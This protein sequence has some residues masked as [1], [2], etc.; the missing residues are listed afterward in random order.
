MPPVGSD[1]FILRVKLRLTLFRAFNGTIQLPDAAQKVVV[2]F[3]VPDAQLRGVVEA[4]KKEV[5]LGLAKDGQQIK[6]LPSFVTNLPPADLVSSSL[7][8]DLGGTNFRVCSVSMDRGKVKLE[9]EKFTIPAKAKETQE[10]LFGFLAESINTFIE[11]KGA[12][13]TMNL[14]FT[15]SFPV[16]QT[17]ICSGTLVTWTK[18]F[19]T[20]GVVGVEV[21]SL[22]QSACARI[23]LSKL[24]ITALVNDTVGTLMAHAVVA[25]NTRVGMIV[26]T[27]FN[28]AYVEKRERIGKMG[29]VK[30]GEAPHMVVNLESGNFG[31]GTDALPL[32][33][34]VFSCWRTTKSRLMSFDFF[35][36]CR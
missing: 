6:C 12:D 20:P 10:G 11:K 27:G 17:S 36:F 29:P 33:M 26:G 1:T 9:Q 7:A 25:E 16:Q 2:A 13:G 14:G 3:H 5:E 18:G 19:S 4:F 21:V 8:L 22:L 35:S 15:F 31:S 30:A 28:A 32:S 34:W 23:G 24:N